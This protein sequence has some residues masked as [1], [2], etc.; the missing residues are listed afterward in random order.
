MSIRED[1]AAWKLSLLRAANGRRTYAC[2]STYTCEF[3]GVRFT[4][5][6]LTWIVYGGVYYTDD[7]VYF[8]T[9]KPRLLTR[10]QTA[11]GKWVVRWTHITK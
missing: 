1:R 10:R 9:C 3:W 8:R 11:K 2:H 5:D 4:P 7:K 6:N